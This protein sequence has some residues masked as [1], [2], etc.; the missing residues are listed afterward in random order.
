MKRPYIAN[1]GRK[2]TNDCEIC[3]C[4]N[5]LNHSETTIKPSLNTIGSKPGNDTD[6]I[7]DVLKVESSNFD[8]L[9]TIA[10]TNETRAVEPADP[11]DFLSVL[12]SVNENT[13]ETSTVEPG[14]PDDF[15]LMAGTDFTKAIEPSDP[16]DFNMLHKISMDE[17][18][19]TENLEPSDP[20]DF[21]SCN[22]TIIDGTKQTFT[23]EPSDP[24]DFLTVLFQ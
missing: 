9:L 24:D 15:L 23:L 19:L 11:D 2:L 3:G 17:T 1:Y 16:D 18:G 14:D 5:E 6:G 8:N 4:S 7:R 10:G 20:D 21:L 13:I 22:G 12:N